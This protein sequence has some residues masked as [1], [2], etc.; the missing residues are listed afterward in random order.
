MGRVVSLALCDRKRDI[1]LFCPPFTCAR[2]CRVQIVYPATKVIES[3]VGKALVAGNFRAITS[4]A[5]RAHVTHFCA[6]LHACAVCCCCVFSDEDIRAGQKIYRFHGQFLETPNI[7]TVQLEDSKHILCTG[8][9]PVSFDSLMLSNGRWSPVHVAQ[10]RPQ[11][12]LHV[13]RRIWFARARTHCG[14]ESFAL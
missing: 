1:L 10:L 4:L 6:L 13:R 14:A 11:R 12:L 8:P 2:A 9:H 5:L 7:Y 3:I